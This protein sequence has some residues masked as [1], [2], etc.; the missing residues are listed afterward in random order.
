MRFLEH[1]TKF[2][3]LLS[4][5]LFYLI[6]EY[7]NAEYL[8]VDEWNSYYKVICRLDVCEFLVPANPQLP[9]I[10][11]CVTAESYRPDP[12]ILNAKDDL[13]DEQNAPDAKIEKLPLLCMTHN[14][15][16]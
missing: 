6:N 15:T 1:Q 3:K 8:T 12:K 14:V 9:R 4:T 13:D 10:Y 16:F 2:F 5:M 11:E 7:S